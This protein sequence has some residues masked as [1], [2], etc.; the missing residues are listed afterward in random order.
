MGLD[1]GDQ[2]PHNHENSRKPRVKRSSSQQQAIKITVSC[3]VKEL[4]PKLDRWRYSWNYESVNTIRY[5]YVFTAP[6]LNEDY[7]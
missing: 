1:S 5:R 2:T 6:L 4:I 3:E 7:D